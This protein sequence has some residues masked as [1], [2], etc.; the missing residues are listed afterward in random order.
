MRV[1]WRRPRVIR[2]GSQRSVSPT[3][4]IKTG[5]VNRYPEA[6]D[7]V[8]VYMLPVILDGLMEQKAQSNACN[9]KIGL[10]KQLQGANRG[11]MAVLGSARRSLRHNH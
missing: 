11:P 10:A 8:Q 6:K 2:H 1:N 3:A 4:V 9:L 7:V 5:I